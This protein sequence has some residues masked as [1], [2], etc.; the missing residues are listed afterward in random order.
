MGLKRGL[1]AALFLASCATAPVVHHD[2]KVEFREAGT[3]PGF[4]YNVVATRPNGEIWTLSGSVWSAFGGGKDPE[5]FRKR[6]SAADSRALTELLSDPAFYA[7]KH[8]ER[9]N[10]YFS[11][12]TIHFEGRDM[13]AR[14]CPFADPAAPTTRVLSLLRRPIGG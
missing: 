8:L 2:D 11:I 1:L 3:L 10:D 14:L 4:S 6:L 5:P 13:E 7:T 9:C 12:L